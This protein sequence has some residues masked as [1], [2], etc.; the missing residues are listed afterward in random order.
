MITT[1]EQKSLQDKLGKL[2]PVPDAAASAYLDKLPILTARVDEQILG[3]SDISDLIGRCPVD[4]IT[5][6]HHNYGRFMATVFSMDLPALFL[7]MVPWAYHV[8]TTRGVSFDYFAAELSAWKDAVESELDGALARPISRVYRWMIE[9]HEEMKELSGTC[10]NFPAPEPDWSDEREALL[11]SLLEGDSAAVRRMAGDT[12]SEP[13]ELPAYY[14]GRVQPVMYRVGSLWAE[15]RV[16]VAQ[17]HMATAIMGRVMAETYSRF[18]IFDPSK[19]KAIVACATDEFHELGARIVTDLLELDGWDVMFLGANVPDH[20]FQQI[21]QEA[22]PRIVALSAA[23]PS[24]L[25]RMRDMA[26]GVRKESSLDHTRV[27]VG[28]LALTT[29]PEAVDKLNVDG[30]AEDGRGARRMAHRWWEEGGWT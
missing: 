10:G 15:G 19:G 20:D 17:E 30:F 5:T 24:H 6:N 28:G 26:E 12:V 18:Q 8:Y 29:A 16:S 2:F 3:R 13:A 4:I 7:R 1:V 14:V 11:S 9:H 27:M 21:V 23:V 22:R 25:L